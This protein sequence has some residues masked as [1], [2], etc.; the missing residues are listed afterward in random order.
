MVSEVY[1]DVFQVT[2]PM[3]GEMEAGHVYLIRGVN[4]HLVVD[5]GWGQPANWERIVDGVDEAGVD[6]VAKPVTVLLTHA[7]PDHTG[8][9]DDL[10]DRFDAEV[11]IH[12]YEELFFNINTRYQTHEPSH[13]DA[14]LETHGVEH[15]A[16][17]NQFARSSGYAMP[18]VDRNLDGAET[19]DT[20]NFTF[21]TCW[22]PGH[23]PGHL[24]LYEPDHELFLSGDHL[25]AHTTPNIGLHPWSPSNPLG[26]YLDALADVTALD[27]ELVLP[28][29]GETFTDLAAQAES[30]LGH[31]EERADEIHRAVEEGPK[32]AWE[33]AHW[34]SWSPGAFEDLIATGKELA[35]LETLAH[36]EYMRSDRS[37]RKEFRS[38]EAKFTV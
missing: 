10:R 16:I 17:E 15:D 35:F 38:G 30:V 1:P 13:V 29:H 27:T 32:T 28:G 23:A 11:V 4:R 14:W 26:D 8:Q 2:L 36:L 9:A 24:C 34:I 7:H 21:R 37:V 6:L 25:L 22:T 33:V 31:H 12:P 19:I 20:G 18:A 5:S 3:P